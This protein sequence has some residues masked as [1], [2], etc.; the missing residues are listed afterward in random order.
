[1]VALHKLDLCP[2]QNVD[3]VNY[4][5]FGI[6]SKNRVEWGISA[7]ACMSSSVSI[8]P[9]YESLGA[10]VIAFVLNQT[11]LTT[12][13]CENVK[14][15][16]TIMGLKRAGKIPKLLNVI[17]FDQVGEE[18]MEEAKALDL[19]VYYFQ[20][21]IEI[22]KQEVD[23]GL[24]EPKP[25]TIYMICYTSGTT[26]DPKGVMI[27]HES[28]VSLIHLADQFMVN[29]DETDIAISY[30]PYGHTFEQCIFIFSLF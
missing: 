17:T 10:D 16:G 24:E 8:V 27:A 22:G 30:L 25:E 7:L 13:C 6:I 26:G 2:D 12:I 21:L 29:F 3:G 18:K 5:F 20:D 14:Y 23:V 15:L 1:M 9:F 4:K 28:F 19:K 11:E